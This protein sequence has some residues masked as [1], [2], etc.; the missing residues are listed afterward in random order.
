MVV[1][2]RQDKLGVLGLRAIHVSTSARVGL[3]YWC[4]SVV[5]NIYWCAYLQGNPNC[6]FL[7]K[8][9]P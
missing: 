7:V 9:F 8:S 2:L 1:W 4:S 3:T 5:V 6:E